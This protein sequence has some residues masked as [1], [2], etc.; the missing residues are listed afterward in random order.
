MWLKRRRAAVKAVV[1]KRPRTRLVAAVAALDDDE[2]DTASMAKLRR[3]QK[4]KHDRAKV[5]AYLDGVI[6]EDRDLRA[7]ADKEMQD[8]QRRGK[9]RRKM[10]KTS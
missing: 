8:R 2:D 5:E 1:S 6:P 10:T 3:K 4:E 9:E 7:L